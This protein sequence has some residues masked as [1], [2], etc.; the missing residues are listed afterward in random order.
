MILRGH[1]PQAAPFDPPDGAATFRS[2]TEVF[3]I[4]MRAEVERSFE[5]SGWPMT[6]QAWSAL[7]AATA[8]MSGE[9][10]AKSGYV[11][12]HLDGEDDAPTFMPN[13]VGQQ[14][15]RRL[16]TSDRCWPERP[17]LTNLTAC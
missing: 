17:S 3:V 2:S 6:R 7:E 9:F 11:S 15:L 13:V 14:L 4:A 1:P 10:V 12:G 5:T 8:H 16:T